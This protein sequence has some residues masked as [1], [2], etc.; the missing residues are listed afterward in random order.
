MKVNETIPRHTY[1]IPAVLAIQEAKG[2]RVKVQGQPWQL[3][4]TLSHVKK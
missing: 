1:E 4:G 3:T 2:K